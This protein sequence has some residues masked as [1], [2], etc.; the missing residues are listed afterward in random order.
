MRSTRN[1]LNDIPMMPFKHQKDWAAWLDKNHAA[2]SGVWLRLAKKAS[3]LQSVSYCEALEAA[4]CYGWIDGIQTAKKAETRAKRIQQFIRML[5][6]N[7]K[8]HP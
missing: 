6:K 7:E 3:S 8:L 2:S 1:T 5:E 4:L